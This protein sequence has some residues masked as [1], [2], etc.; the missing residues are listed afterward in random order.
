MTIAVHYSLVELIGSRA[1]STDIFYS[2]DPEQKEEVSM[3]AEVNAHSPEPTPQE[4]QATFHLA[5]QAAKQRQTLADQGFFNHPRRTCDIEQE[6]QCLSAQTGMPMSGEA[7]IAS[8]TLPCARFDTVTSIVEYDAAGI[9]PLERDA[10]VGL[11]HSLI[12]RTRCM[13]QVLAASAAEAIIVPIGVQPLV[14]ANSWQEW[15]VPQPGMRRRYHL[16]DAATRQENPHGVIRIASPDGQTVFTEV[17]SYMAVMM[18]CAGTQFHISECCVEEALEAHTI[19]IFI[20]PIMSALFGNSP[21]VGGIDSGRTSTRIALF[22]EGEPSRAGLPRPSHTLYQY[23]EQQLSRALPP[24]VVTDDPQQALTLSHGTIHTTSRIQVDM[25]NA[26]IRNEFR[27]IDAQ[28][29][30]R[31]MQAFLL[32]LGAI[33]GLRGRT[34][35]T[36]EESRYNLRKAV[37]GLHAPMCLQGRATTALT[38]AKEL[39][40][41]AQTTLQKKGLGELSREFLTP[42]LE[43]ELEDGRTQADILRERVKSE[44]EKGRSFQ[45]AIVE[46]MRECSTGR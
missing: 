35:A 5:L 23:Y 6:I 40:A 9:T 18:R 46:A 37:W 24:F 15:I 36:Y 21:F 10:L 17:A 38:L 20:T 2:S 8:N 34:L 19:S 4:A 22:L 45:Q 11:Y 42:L 43:N 13:Q 29:P 30:F 44:V 12:Q 41:I 1:S 3:G 28:S 14:E 32:T 27:C 31:S 26:T 39:V 16:I 7:L 33:D 25:A